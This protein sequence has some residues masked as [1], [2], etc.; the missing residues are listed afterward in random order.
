VRYYY[1][2]NLFLGDNEEHRSEMDRIVNETVTRHIWS[3]LVERRLTPDVEVRLLRQYGLRRYNEESQMA[4]ATVSA[5]HG[6]T[7]LSPP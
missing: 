1:A 5:A 4:A 2:P 6:S 3:A 7:P